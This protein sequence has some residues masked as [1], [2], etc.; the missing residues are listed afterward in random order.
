M[1][2]S[3]VQVDGEDDFSLPVYETCDTMRRKIRDVL[4]KDGLIQAGF[5]SAMAQAATTDKPP[6]PAQLARFLSQKGPLSGNTSVVFYA[7]YV[8]LEKM[9]IRDLK[10]RSKFRQ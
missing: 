4:K 1:D 3:S 7:S 6:Q 10:P 5:C 2:I 8:L 9:R